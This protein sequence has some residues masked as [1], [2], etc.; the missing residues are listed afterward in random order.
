VREASTGT[1]NGRVR[2]PCGSPRA[3]GI[4]LVDNLGFAELT[5]KAVLCEKHLVDVLDGSLN[6]VAAF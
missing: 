4:S 3:L 5:T 2:A 1:G 6:G